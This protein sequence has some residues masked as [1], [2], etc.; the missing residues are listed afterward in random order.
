MKKKL[1]KK[2]RYGINNKKAEQ[3]E[4]TMAETKRIKEID[5]NRKNKIKTL[6]PFFE[7]LVQDFKKNLLK[8]SQTYNQFDFSGTENINTGIDYSYLF[9]RLNV[10]GEVAVSQNGG[11]AQLHGF[12]ANPHPRLFLTVLYRN[13]QKEYQNFYSNAFAENSYNRNERGI[14]TGVRFNIHRNW[15]ITSYLDNFVFPWIKYRVDAPSKGNEY[16]VQLENSSHEKL[17][18][19]FRFRQKNKQINEAVREDHI[20]E[21][22]NTRKNYFR[23]HIEYLISAS[24][25]LKNRVEYV[26]F[27]EGSVYKG[28]G[29]LIYQDIAWRSKSEKLSLVFRYAL[30]D[31]DSYDERIYAYENDV[32]YAFSV[33]A[34]YYNGMRGIVML[35]FKLTRKINFWV[36]FAH[37]FVGNKSVLG[38]GLDEINDHN[39]SEIK[40]QLRVKI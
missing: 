38:T 12:T 20:L 34:Y 33:P 13:Y 40:I 30:F 7:E 27:K 11:L 24:V 5:I 2:I 22:M 32:L 26:I 35:N 17:F 10:F 9:N 4:R 15:F 37:T 21:V 23:F 25:K 36:R 29:Y 18:Y 3:K 31:T 1:E 14:Y 8:D 6:L 16:L 39:R 19:Y 28:T